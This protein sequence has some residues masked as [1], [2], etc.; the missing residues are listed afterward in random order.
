MV[1]EQP[2]FHYSQ[3][4][5]SHAVTTH[6]KAMG[7]SIVFVPDIIMPRPNQL[8]VCFELLQNVGAVHYSPFLISMN[9]FFNILIYLN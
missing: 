4:T 9:F 6:C 2:L 1:V 7:P 5:P 8:C 3:A